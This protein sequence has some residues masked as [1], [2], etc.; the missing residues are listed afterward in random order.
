MVQLLLTVVATMA[1]LLP[2]VAQITSP[3]E[4]M[5]FK[6]P[7][8]VLD[9]LGGVPD[10]ACESLVTKLDTAVEAGSVAEYRFLAEVENQSASATAPYNYWVEVW[11]KSARDFVNNRESLVPEATSLENHQHI[12]TTGIGTCKLCPNSTAYQPYD[13][14]KVRHGYFINDQRVG[15]YPV[16]TT[17]Q[18]A[19]PLTAAEKGTLDYEILLGV[20]NITPN[21]VVFDTDTVSFLE[22][23]TDAI[24][25]DQHVFNV[26]ETFMVRGSSQLK[27][28]REVGSKLVRGHWSSLCQVVP[29]YQPFQVVLVLRS[30]PNRLVER[31]VHQRG[32]VIQKAS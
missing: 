3:L 8:V 15:K 24:A 4:T 22:V 32:A 21:E 19:L 16:H 13:L 26:N 14:S 6:Y 29:D 25:F 18:A 12:L 2:A 28:S 9:R 27:Y 30:A 23:Y 31:P 11:Y 5:F 1:Q 10:E 20:K 7:V 17:F